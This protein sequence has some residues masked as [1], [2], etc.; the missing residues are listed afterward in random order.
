MKEEDIR[1]LKK[2]DH[3][4]LYD[5]ITCEIRGLLQIEAVEN[6]EDGSRPFW[7]YNSQLGC[8]MRW[9][10]AFFAK[11]FGWIPHEWLTTMARL[12]DDVETFLSAHPEARELMDSKGVYRS[13]REVVEHH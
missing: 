11:D 5:P 9:H 3:I 12:V 10:P 7:K 2:G 13:I 8:L 1:K 4:A 6:D